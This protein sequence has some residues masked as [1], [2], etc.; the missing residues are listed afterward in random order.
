MSSR[1]Q[2][3]WKHFWSAEDDIVACTERE[4]A[5]PEPDFDLPPDSFWVPKSHEKYWVDQRA[6]VQHKSSMKL[7][8]IHG[9]SNRHSANNNVKS[10]SH[11]FSPSSASPSPKNKASSFIGLPKTPNSWLVDG[12]GRRSKGGSA[13]L[14]RSRSEPGEN[15]VLE[16]HEPGSPK[17][18]C[19]GRVEKQKGKA[20]KG[21]GFWI[22][23]KS[24]LRIGRGRS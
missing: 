7:S 13:R 20:K 3:L 4:W 16:I 12:Y 9:K 6:L 8:N 17:V 5:S 10:F 18:S 22:S 14:F 1:T 23:F 24:I 2:K 21:P 19:I 15:R 11:R